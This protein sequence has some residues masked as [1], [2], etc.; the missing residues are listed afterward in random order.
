MSYQKLRE[1]IPSILPSNEVDS[2]SLRI[3]CKRQGEGG[4]R[5]ATGNLLLIL[6]FL[7][8]LPNLWGAQT[9]T[10]EK[11]LFFCIFLP[12][13]VWNWT[14]KFFPVKH[15]YPLE[16]STVF[17]VTDCKSSLLSRQKTGWRSRLKWITNNNINNTEYNCQERDEPREENATFKAN[18]SP[19]HDSSG[20]LNQKFS[21]IHSE[22]LP[23]FENSFPL[24]SSV[25]KKL[26][27]LISLFLFNVG[28]YYSQS[29]PNV[30]VSSS[31]HFL[32]IH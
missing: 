28:Q 4:T 14:V 10:E 22:I 15:S 21:L 27:G 30:Q 16:K 20:T 8:L 18:T 12:A 5:D 32:L 31:F 17:Q 25:I 29:S 6:L 3:P 13:R 19:G 23:N 1:V 7:L 11:F 9:K 24:F 26:L 2:V